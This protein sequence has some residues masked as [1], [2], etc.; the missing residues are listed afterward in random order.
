MKLFLYS[1]FSRMHN[2]VSQN[3]KKINEGG[4]I[5]YSNFNFIDHNVIYNNE[6]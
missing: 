4:R 2:F 5:S 1:L 3:K 6:A